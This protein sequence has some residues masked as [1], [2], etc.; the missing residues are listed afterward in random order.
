MAEV[1]GLPK[2]VEEEVEAYLACGQLEAGCL[3]LV[4]RDCGRGRLVAFSCKR[5][6][7]CPSCLGRRMSDGAVQQV[8]PM[9]PV[10]RFPWGVRSVLGYDQE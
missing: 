8:L 5:R 9:V 3:E 7:F 2:F 6:G 1:G 10:R 4:C